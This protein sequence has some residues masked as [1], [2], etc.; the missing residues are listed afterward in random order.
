MSHAL[1]DTNEILDHL[2]SNLTEDILAIQNDLDTISHILA[3]I[4]AVQSNHSV[5]VNELSTALES[6][7]NETKPLFDV[8]T[9]SDGFPD[10]I[11]CEVSGIQTI[12]YVWQINY[13][14]FTFYSDGDVRV[15]NDAR[16][17]YAVFDIH[18]EAVEMSPYCKG[19][20]IT[21]LYAQH[22]AFNFVVS[23]NV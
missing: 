16:G 9:M 15:T 11:I 7:V 19:V 22:K 20:N 4:Q 6:V 10:A 13:G 17:H 12:F 18:G 21:Q 1:K 14:S 23:A 3:L 5:H 2:H 8:S